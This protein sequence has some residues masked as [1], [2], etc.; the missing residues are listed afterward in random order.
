MKTHLMCAML[1]AALMMGTSSSVWAKVINDKTNEAGVSANILKVQKVKCDFYDVTCG[2]K[3]AAGEKCPD[4]QRHIGNPVDT[5]NLGQLNPVLLDKGAEGALQ[6]SV[7]G[8][9]ICGVTSNTGAPYFV[10]YVGGPLKNTSGT[11]IPSD[12]YVLSMDP[13]LD[14]NGNLGK[15]NP[16]GSKS[17]CDS[18]G[19]DGQL[20]KGRTPGNGKFADGLGVLPADGSHQI[21]TSKVITSTADPFLKIPAGGLKHPGVVFRGGVGVTADPDVTANKQ[22]GELAGPGQQF[23]TYTSKITITLNGV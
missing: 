22:N 14:Y 7:R 18:D 8:E 11:A 10:T 16:D 13:C 2:K 6:S 19:K 20:A 12:A 15:T 9:F 17:G 5:L 4:D 23:G 3:L 1:A 21:Y